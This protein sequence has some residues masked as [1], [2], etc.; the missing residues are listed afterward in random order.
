MCS[1]SLTVYPNAKQTQHTHK[2]M[3]IKNILPCLD[4]PSTLSVMEAE[5]YAA[6]RIFVFHQILKVINS[7]PMSKMAN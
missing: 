3:G 7:T 1:M 6:V 4:A 5:K 2:L